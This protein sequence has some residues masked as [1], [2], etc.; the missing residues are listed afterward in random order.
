MFPLNEF[1]Q[2]QKISKV[3]IIMTEKL[4]N[5]SYSYKMLLCNFTTAKFCTYNKL[6]NENDARHRNQ[7]LYVVTKLKILKVN[8]YLDK[9][10]NY[11][12]FGIIFLTA[13]GG[14][15]YDKSSTLVLRFSTSCSD[16]HF[17]IFTQP[18]QP[19]HVAVTNESIS[20]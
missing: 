13:I 7:P 6:Y 16:H 11:S 9:Y 4:K 19:H 12:K 17:L 14:H 10:F 8:I 2:P 3:L 15:I 18:L 5:V 1:N 20:I